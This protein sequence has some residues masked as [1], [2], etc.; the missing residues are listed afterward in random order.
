M[1]RFLEEI[2]MKS[3]VTSVLNRVLGEF[4]ENLDSD[5]LNMSLLS[6]TVTLNDLR[7][8]RSAIEK[9]GFPFTIQ[10]GFLKRVYVKV[11][12]T[13]LTSSPLQVEV[14]GLHLH[15]ETTS[16][17]HWDTGLV[18]EMLSQ[19]KQVSLSRFELMH[20]PEVEVSTSPG[21]AERLVSKIV[22]NLQLEV[23]GVFV[24]LEDRVSSIHPFALGVTL[25]R[26]AAVTCNSAWKP[27]YIEEASVQY[28][29]IS[30]EGLSIYLD[31]ADP[32]KVNSSE[33]AGGFKKLAEKEA[34]LTPP[35]KHSYLI[36]PV[37]LSLKLIINTSAEGWEPLFQALLNQSALKVRVEDLHVTHL[38]KFFA[39][40]GLFTTF[41]Q[42]V[43]A[44]LPKVEFTE[45]AAYDYRALYLAFKQSG[46][47]EAIVAF[48]RDF[49]YDDL[50]RQRLI[51]LEERRLEEAEDLKLQEIAQLEESAQAGYFSG[52][53]SWFGY[54]KSAAEQQ[55]EDD[56]RQAKIDA[57]RAELVRIRKK[58]SLFASDMDQFLGKEQP[59]LSEFADDYVKMQV[60]IDLEKLQLSI[61]QGTETKL[62]FQA[63]SFSMKAGVRPS[64]VFAEFSLQET[65]VQDFTSQ[66]SVF[67]ML[68]QGGLLEGR[69][70]QYPHTIV[71]L[72]SEALQVVVNLRALLTIGR[73]FREAVAREV[74]LDEYAKAAASL[75]EDY[76][77]AGR[78][79]VQ[80][81]FQGDYQYN[82]IDL[83][84]ALKAPVFIFPLD[85]TRS[86]DFIVFDLGRLEASTK[87]VMKVIAMVDYRLIEADD[88]LYDIYNFSLSEV[89]LSS[90]EAC[91]AVES[92]K[93]GQWTPL[94]S[95]QELSLKVATCIIQDHPLKPVLRLES[96]Q[97]DL[98][99]H[100]SDSQLLLLLKLKASGMDTLEEYMPAVPTQTLHIGIKDQMKNIGPVISQVFSFT[101]ESLV[102][103]TDLKDTPLL[104]LSSQQFS[105]VV[106]LAKTG[107][108]A[109]KLK[110]VKVFIEDLR[111]NSVSRK[112]LYCPA[113][114]SA[115]QGIPQLLVEL[116]VKSQDDSTRLSVVLNDLCLSAVP[117]FLSS[118]MSFYSDPFA[119]LASTSPSSC[120][121]SELIRI[122]E[123]EIS[124][125]QIKPAPASEVSAERSLTCYFKLANFQL[126][127][128][129][130]PRV[131][132]FHFGMNASYSS[133]QHYRYLLDAQGYV[134]D[135]EYSYADDE[136]S[137]EMFQLGLQVLAHNSKLLSEMLVP[138]RISA[139]YSTFQKVNAIDCSVELVIEAISVLFGFR[140][141]KQLQDISTKWLQILP[142]QS[143]AV[144]AAV[145]A[146]VWLPTIYSV[147]LQCDS[148]QFQLTDDT[149]EQPYS[150]IYAQIPNLTAGF[151]Y[152]ASLTGALSIS[153][154]ADY[155][156]V[157]KRAWE[158]LI[159]EWTLELKA[160][161][162]ED[163]ALQLSST[164]TL[165]LNLSFQMLQV[166]TTL[167][168]RL[169]Q[170]EADWGSVLS[171]SSNMN[172]QAS[173][174][175]I[176]NRL[177][178]NVYVWVD[179][180]TNMDRWLLK[181]DEARQ[182]SRAYIEDI[183]NAHSNTRKTSLYSLAQPAACIAVNVTS[184]GTARGLSLDDV[185]TKS[186]L[187]KEG[188]RTCEC[189]LAIS[190]KGREI[191]VSLENSLQVMNNLDFSVTLFHRELSLNV[192][193][194]SAVSLPIKWVRE[195]TFIAAEEG[196]V[197]I[198]A[199]K[200]CVLAGH[201]ISVDALQIKV[202]AEKRKAHQVVVQLN[203][204]FTIQNLLPCLVSIHQENSEDALAVIEPGSECPLYNL[205]PGS[206]MPVQIKLHLGRDRE[207]MTDWMPIEKSD[208]PQL[209]GNFP[210]HKLSVEV[211][212]LS[213]LRN[214]A[215]DLRFVKAE[216]SLVKA[217]TVRLF[218]QFLI[219]NKTHL[220]L[221]CGKRTQMA[222]GPNSFSFFKSNRSQLKI[223]RA[224]T[225][226]AKPSKWSDGFNIEAAGIAGSVNLL[227][228]KANTA[229]DGPTSLLLGVVM[230]NAPPPL[231]KTKIVYI[232]PRF[233][234]HNTL[235]FPLYLRQ[236]GIN[237]P[238]VVEAGAKL[239]LVL[240]DPAQP[241]LIQVSTDQEYWSAGINV[242]TIEDFQVKVRSS[243]VEDREPRW[244]E[245]S[246][247][248]YFMQFIRVVIISEDDA[249]I[250]INLLCPRDPEFQILNLSHHHLTFRQLGHPEYTVPAGEVMPFAF[251]DP[252]SRKIV[253]RVEG[254]EQA[255][256]FEKVKKLKSLHD[257]KVNCVV[258]GVTRVLQLM[259]KKKSS[260]EHF[261][262]R[263][264]SRYMSQSRSIQKS[265]DLE[266]NLF[267]VGLSI[268]DDTPRE[269]FF[270]SLSDIE[271][272]V[273]QHR[274]TSAKEVEVARKL[275][276]KV[277][278]VQLDNML[279]KE[280]QFR[281][282]LCPTQS[283]A[284]SEI[285]FFQLGVHLDSVYPSE[286]IK[287]KNVSVESASMDRITLLS[288]SMQEIQVKLDQTT[289]Y[290]VVDLLTRLEESMHST[291]SEIRRS[292]NSTVILP[293]DTFQF[294]Q[295][296]QP[297]LS[298]DA[299]QMSRKAYI[300]N[301]TIFGVKVVL[302]LRL[303][304]RKVQLSPSQGFGLLV[305]I[306]NFG[307][308]LANV[309][310]SPLYFKAVVFEHLFQTMSNLSWLML[311]NYSRQGILQFYKV[312]GSSDLLG[313]PIG[314]IDK[315]GSGVME[316][317]SEPYKGM[318]KGPGEFVE[319]VSKGVRA[320]VGN[321][322]SGSF[323]SVSKITGSLYTIVHE[324]TG[325]E[326]SQLKEGDNVFT[327][328]YLGLTGGVTELASGLA[329]FFTKPIQGAKRSGVLGFFKGVGAGVLGV[330]TAPLA[331]ALRLGSSVATGISNTGTL[332]SKGKIQHYGRMR[333]PRQ[334][335]VRRIL[336]PYDEELAQAQ[337]LINTLKNFKRQQIA[338]YVQVEADVMVILTLKHLFLLTAGDL[339]KS[340]KLTA[341]V[342]CEV[343]RI[344]EVFYFC[345]AT[346]RNQIVVRSAFYGPLARLFLV[347]SS[348]P[349]G[350][351]ST[352]FSAKYRF[353]QSYG[354]G[355]CG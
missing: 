149:V 124:Q 18:Q 150:L 156:N 331:A 74:N 95:Q 83:R 284:S 337:E 29:Q 41:C 56:E 112:V 62:T 128:P 2:K 294:V 326:P 231:L 160:V 78:E 140:D 147:T 25:K 114:D 57:A 39:F 240:D 194:L 304:Q 302:S 26:L 73:I 173:I 229:G 9:F 54:G 184:E 239:P 254:H 85:L 230:Y 183:I 58:Q 188:D 347:L 153:F 106:H 120:S 72:R 143:E 3:A 195:E 323:G 223:R 297:T 235:R 206:H 216:K 270:M 251:D 90:V 327:G 196:H 301:M 328:V 75:A 241:R 238:V 146:E 66:G 185:G 190:T 157:P 221:E 275:E 257:C 152:G 199:N 295:A 110:L 300:Q 115:V 242:E 315:L 133:T 24:R 21:F 311:K 113:E 317:F 131:L 148:I 217:K 15:L 344:N 169:G 13:S 260:K 222:L 164:Q 289:L 84:L 281:V 22:N 354:R 191:Q 267:A 320:L 205:V 209:K 307:S 119:E 259:P 264:L 276:V 252:E 154:N 155:Y 92:W 341:V 330:V 127:L 123:G 343:H 170:N 171:E 98:K 201:N 202:K 310:E 19:I 291:V 181:P 207:L 227:N 290:E 55:A 145:V 213:L 355:C 4:V 189:L 180:P 5:N 23:T 138:C 308:A 314:L 263:A 99:V 27:E 163:I 203:P 224:E 211:E 61:C 200:T 33:F 349:T 186:F 204:A 218:A 353:D 269:R 256:S 87:R 32:V 271:I 28:K 107:S 313:N 262:R 219:V 321:V 122:V 228:R 220:T 340:M 50:V 79:Y 158:P 285:P 214:H 139:S 258:M 277:G 30:L 7:I 193:S 136:A 329:G 142:Q 236:M 282:I 305:L 348:M 208:H 237:S 121:S 108:L 47:P 253:V 109:V 137:L 105:T 151:D 265:I 59:S 346:R 306:S 12:W 16:K 338:C 97:R 60:N 351:S 248:N 45:A 144:S 6:G 274:K 167:G 334:F 38:L 247:K 134:Q 298:F 250:F 342:N 53:K 89:V 233:I 249:T 135:I 179:V 63:N 309:S 91:S 175:S 339:K 125:P 76:I 37:F 177:G 198:N 322:I 336:E 182:M 272:N 80:G 293:E 278:H 332:L 352:V 225:E 48:E 187:L 292:R 215:L 67:P 81:M 312:I 126:L 34:A 65:R 8:K 166:L 116:E 46:K 35:F 31:Y 279:C 14:A 130:A 82:S 345:A 93:E 129:N 96:V 212:P 52:V 159:E 296:Y 266:V 88:Q 86:S 324:A 94:Y 168:E 132:S 243:A 283:F 288:I 43:E 40:Y 20:S 49:K 273:R 325:H 17:E 335:G 10:S 316:F 102:V 100:L 1:T 118:L 197:L 103:E 244:Y 226:H 162:S 165:N 232:V 42:G 44:Q 172:S 318:L 104:R 161:E 141:L 174:Y 176:V 280:N 11:P 68:L 101:V 77:K 192:G 71:G 117:D 303:S 286:Q 51:I 70:D 255:Y 69:Y 234:L 261:D 287:A 333:F 178:V 246:D 36:E 245:P 268:I 64:S 299:T 350:L 210:A 319:G 111:P